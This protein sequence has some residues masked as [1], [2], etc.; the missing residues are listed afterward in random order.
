MTVGVRTGA[1]VV[2]TEVLVLV[3]TVVQQ[4]LHA[5]SALSLMCAAVVRIRIRI[6]YPVTDHLIKSFKNKKFFDVSNGTNMKL[7]QEGEKTRYSRC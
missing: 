2:F 6:I 4:A 5:G 7:T 1:N 3:M